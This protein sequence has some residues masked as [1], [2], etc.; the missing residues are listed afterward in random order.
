[1]ATGTSGVNPQARSQVTRAMRETSSSSTTQ[2][3]REELVKASG[4]PTDIYDGEVGQ[5]HLEKSG[6]LAAGAPITM[7]ALSMAALR[8]SQCTAKIPKPIM[9]GIRALAFVMEKMATDQMVEVV[10][11]AVVEK[12]TPHLEQA[13]AATTSITSAVSDLSL[14]AVGSTKAI[15]DFREEFHDLTKKLSDAVEVLE[16]EPLAAPAPAATASYANVLRSQ[17]QPPPTHVAAVARGQTKEQQILIEKAPDADTNGLSDLSEKELVA[18][19]NMTRHLMGME[20]GDAPPNTVFVGAQK[21][22]NGG[23]LLQLNSVAAADWLRQSKVMKSFLSHLGG[24]S[25][26]KMRL[27]NTVMEY[28]PV[29]FDPTA[30]GALEAVEDA[31]GLPRASILSAKFIKPVQLH[32]VGQGTAHAIFGF[33]S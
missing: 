8:L 33:G 30:F 26:L 13:T 19:A 6:Y 17:Q 18:K 16:A 24:T 14:V 15:N 2:K 20:A 12:L 11:L 10:A 32:V 22:R 23:V 31:S 1:M 5:Q 3:T 29:S 4:I 7:S 9:E 27:L 21:L 28:I 25:V